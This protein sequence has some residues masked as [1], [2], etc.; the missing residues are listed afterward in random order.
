[1][2]TFRK[3]YSNG[4]TSSGTMTK[5]VELTNKSRSQSE[6]SPNIPDYSILNN[7]IISFQWKTDK[8]LT[9]G[10]CQVYVNKSPDDWLSWDDGANQIG[11]TSKSK[12]SYVSVYLDKNS[13][14]E[15][16][17]SRLPDFFNSG[18][19]NVGEYSGSYSVCMWF[20]ATIMRNFYWQNMYMAFDYTPP[21]FVISLSAGTGGT[22]SGAGTYSVGSTA[23]IKAIPNTG[24]RFVKWSDGNTSATRSITKT[25][26]DIS[27]NVTNLSYSAVFEKIKYPVTFKNYDGTVLQTSEIEH[28]NTPS[29][30]GSTPT[31]ATTAEYSYS[32]SGWSPAIGAVTA[33]TTYTAQFTA[34]KRKYTLNVSTGTGGSVSGGGTYEYG[35]TVTLTATPNSG[36]KF[37]QW[38]DGVTTATRTVTVTGNASYTATFELDK[39]NKIYV[40]TAQPKAI[41]VGITLVKAVYIGTT[42]IYG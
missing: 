12:N 20:T 37:K 40:G 1:M 36:Y 2:A 30:T 6:I 5:C 42:K 24:Y 4:S 15:D 22:V 9:A 34:T 31:R 29:Y 7:V 27:A 16:I 41:Y 18:K 25:T 8:S 3:T 13:S 21:T 14:I 33:A 35:S 32:F 39:V 17:S 28:G 19:K 38:S 10:D 11:S 26:S 23:T